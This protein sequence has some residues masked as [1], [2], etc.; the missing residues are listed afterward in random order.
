MRANWIRGLLG[1]GA[2]LFAVACTGS[3]LEAREGYSVAAGG[4]DSDY[5]VLVS[6]PPLTIQS[7]T[8]ALEVKHIPSGLYNVAIA[9]PDGWDRKEFKGKDVQICVDKNDIPIGCVGGDIWGRWEHVIMRSRFC[10]TDQI[11]PSEGG[12]QGLCEARN[13]GRAPYTRRTND[14]SDT[15]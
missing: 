2:A 11:F 15:P 3:H 8:V 7:D 5:N 1:L 10:L 6:F 9:M 4:Y 14:P 12:C 13:K